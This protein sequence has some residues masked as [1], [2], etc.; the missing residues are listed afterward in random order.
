MSET[1]LQGLIAKLERG[2]RKTA[3]AFRSLSPEQ[4]ERPIYDDPETWT[5]RS[6]LAHFLSSERVLLSLCQDVADGGPG[7]PEGFDFDAFNAEQQRILKDVAPAALMDQLV[8]ARTQTLDWLRKLEE[9][10]LDRI[11][12]HPALGEVTLEVMLTAIYGHQ[13]IHMRDLQSKLAC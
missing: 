12:R 11:G 8:A 2:Q 13:L 7:A 10:Q 6:L 1:R 9:N 4:W 5:V 3:E